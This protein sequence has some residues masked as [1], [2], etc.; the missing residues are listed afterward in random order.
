MWIDNF[1]VGDFKHQCEFIHAISDFRKFS[2]ALPNLYEIIFDEM[3]PKQIYEHLLAENLVNSTDPRDWAEATRRHSY[4]RFYG[5][6]FDLLCGFLSL[7]NDQ[8][9][10]LIV[11]YHGRI[12]NDIVRYDIKLKDYQSACKEFTEWFNLNLAAYYPNYKTQ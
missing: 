6:Q 12:G 7:V 1:S 8:F 5:D 4:T 9:L 2:K 3:T 11:H 10:I